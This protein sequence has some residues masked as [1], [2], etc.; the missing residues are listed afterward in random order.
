[1]PVM[2]INRPIPKESSEK[3]RGRPKGAKQKKKDSSNPR[4]RYIKAKRFVDQYLIDLNGIRAWQRC[5]YGTGNI[6]SDKMTVGAFLKRPDVIQLIAEREA[7]RAQKVEISQ[8]MILKELSCIAFF[9]LRDVATWDGE[10]FVLKPFSEL[11]REQTAAFAS[12]KVKSIGKVASELEFRHP[13]PA[14]KRAAL[15]DLGKHIGMFWEAST[16]NDD[17]IESA[18]KIRVALKEMDEMTDPGPTKQ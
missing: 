13:S 14:D 8:E 6:D 17:P 1:M 4:K 2:K 16:K 5:G 15:V 11:T 18:R 9:N 10:R 3:K 7:E 12:I